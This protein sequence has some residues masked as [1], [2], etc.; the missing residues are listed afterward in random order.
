KQSKM[1]GLSAPTKWDDELAK[2]KITP[3][4]VTGVIFTHLHADHA[5]GALKSGSDGNPE[6]RFPNAKMYCQKIEW[7]DAIN[8]NER[9]SA[10]YHVDKLRLFEDSGKLELLDGDTDLFPNIRIKL[11]GG[12]TPGAQGVIVDAGGQ[13]VIYPGDI[14]PLQYNIKVPYVP[15]VDLDPTTTMIQKRWLHEKMLKEDWV[16]AFDHDL[17]YKFA[18]FTT[19][20]KGKIIPVK[21]E[22]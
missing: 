12:H 15:A 10:T 13:R 18:K 4:S 16:L 9:T 3:E 19:N 2:H 20:E 1:F 21:F 17:Q 5:L 7:R 6:L 22:D 14:M 8:P 11:L